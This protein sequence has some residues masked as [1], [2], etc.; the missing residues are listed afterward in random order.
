MAKYTG[1]N[2]FL[3][4]GVSNNINNTDKDPNYLLKEHFPNH[5]FHQALH[6]WALMN[7]ELPLFHIDVHGKLN[8]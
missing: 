5:P 1:K 8:R 6:H 4:W 3:V 2:S 7:Q